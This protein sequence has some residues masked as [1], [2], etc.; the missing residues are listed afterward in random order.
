MAS[1]L[2][3]RVPCAGRAVFADQLVESIAYAKI[4]D[5]GGFAAP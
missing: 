3:K 1:F 2:K 5:A 4:P